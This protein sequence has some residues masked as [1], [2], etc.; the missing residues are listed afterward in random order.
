[1]FITTYRCSC[2]LLES[3][4]DVAHVLFWQIGELLSVVYIV[5]PTSSG[6]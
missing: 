2:E 3:G 4:K 5:S 1:M 6:G